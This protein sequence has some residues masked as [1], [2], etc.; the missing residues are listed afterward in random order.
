MSV[1]VQRDLPAMRI[2]SQGKRRVDYRAFWLLAF[3]LFL[4]SGVQAIL[5]LTDSWFIG[6]LSTDAIAAMGALYFLILVLVTLFGGVG[7]Y[8]Q[9][10]V[11]QAYGNGDRDRAVRAVRAGCW[12]A[13]LLMPLFVVLSFSGSTLLSFLQF[14]PAVEQL[15]LDYW[16]PRI[17]G[18]SIVIASL[19]L[20]SF[21]NGI[22]RSAVTLKVAI[23]IALLNIVLNEVLMFR[24]GMGMAGAAWATTLSLLGG[25]LLL[26]AIFLS[27]QT[28]RRFRSHQVWAPQWKTIRHLFASGIPLGFLMTADLTG[29]ALFQIMQVKLGVVPGAA[30]QLVM[31]LTSTA[32]MPTLGIAQAGTTLVGQSIGAGS[33]RWAQKIGNVSISL[34]VLYAVSVNIL[35][36]LNGQWLVPLFISSAG[37]QVEVVTALSQRLLW[38]AVIYNTFN[39]LSIG[40]AF[41]LQGA[42]DVRIPSFLAIALSWLVY[43]PLTHSLTFGSSE[44]FVRFLP[45]LGWGVWGGWSAAIVFAVMISS[46]LR[47]RWQLRANK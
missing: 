35:I 18:G 14:S 15:A 22:G 7:M 41:C 33:Q 5:N 43:A 29:L 9:T 20:T 42:G 39:A 8:V 13:L 3:P 40:S 16:M 38:L 32:Y 46:L 11:A 36:A 44:G 34:C 10:L 26:L 12:C 25:L 30:T 23:A 37:S 1:S 31:V 28:R 17:L 21:F 6:R 19:A 45:Q 24:M 47:F 4:N 2:G 27:T